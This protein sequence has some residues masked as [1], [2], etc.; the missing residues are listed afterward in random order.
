MKTRQLSYKITVNNQ[1][2]VMVY[3]EQVNF[4]FVRQLKF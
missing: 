3:F 1:T 4:H 2:C